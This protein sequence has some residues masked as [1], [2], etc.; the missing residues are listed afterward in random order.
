VYASCVYCMCR[1]SCEHR[2]RTAVAG[3][4]LHRACVRVSWHVVVA[5]A[6]CSCAHACVRG[7]CVCSCVRACAR[8]WG[9][10]RVFQGLPCHTAPCW[11]RGRVCSATPAGSAWAPRR[12]PRTSCGLWGCTGAAAPRCAVVDRPKRALRLHVF[13]VDPW[14][15][16]P[17]AGTLLVPPRCRGRVL[18]LCARV[19]VTCAF[20]VCLCVRGP[21]V[22]PGR[23]WTSRRPSPFGAAGGTAH[24]REAR[25]PLDQG[26][27]R[28]RV[29]CP[30][31]AVHSLLWSRSRDLLLCRA[32]DVHVS[33]RQKRKR[34]R[35]R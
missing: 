35:S 29:V 17:S 4:A 32:G 33:Y 6:A 10:V 25:P 2:A 28:K 26:L 14:L 23:R 20:G 8:V 30:C 5:R 18:Q 27:F 24:G 3:C 19:C 31:G 15:A 21:A 22:C 34:S 7:C 9:P 1:V 12:C 13:R 16:A 11:C